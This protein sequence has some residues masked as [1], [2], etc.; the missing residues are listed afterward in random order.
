[1]N[2]LRAEEEWRTRGNRRF[3][4]GRVCLWLRLECGHCEQRMRRLDRDGSFVAPKSVKCS[5]CS[6][7]LRSGGGEVVRIGSLYSGIAGLELGL[8]AAFAEAGRPARVAWQC[9]IDPFCARV[10]VH[11]FPDVLRFSDVATVSHPPQVDVLCGGFMCTDVSAAGKGAG[12]G[13]DTRSGHT[14]IHLLRIIDETRPRFIVVENVASGAKRWLPRV[15]QELRDRGY[16]PRAIPLGAV[17]VG[18]P[19]RRL[20]VFV[21]ADRDGAA[22]RGLGAVRDGE[23]EEVGDDADGRRE[24]SI[25]DTERGELR[26]Q[27]GRGSGAGRT[28]TTVAANAAV[29]RR[30]GTYGDRR[31]SRLG[32]ETLKSERCDDA[33][34]NGRTP[35]PAVGSHAHGLP[36]DVAGH[37][38]PAGRGAEQYVWEAPRSLAGDVKVP[39]RPAKLRALGNAVVPQCALVVGRILIAMGA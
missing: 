16:R 31:T 33:E 23:R 30:E 34:S 22:P 1:M 37:T 24:R 19:H 21:V 7:S 38:F 11:H 10:L 20:R 2:V 27:P 5:E 8:L 36:F 29:S 18:A 3:P 4:R 28:D 25:P 39:D 9:E 14:L 17:D 26:Q 32:R 35:Q 13:T 12:L 15:V 6:N